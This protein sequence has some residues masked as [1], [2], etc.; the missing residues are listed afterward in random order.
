MQLG[1]NHK[2][3]NKK[4]LGSLNRDTKGQKMES[5]QAPQYR[6]NACAFAPPPPRQDYCAPAQFVA[7]CGERYLNINR[8]YGRSTLAHQ[9]Q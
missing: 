4:I 3:K 8:A 2:I 1:L 5:Q 9:Y 6:Q 7:T